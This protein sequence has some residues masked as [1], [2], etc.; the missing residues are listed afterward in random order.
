MN[1]HRT[2]Q[3]NGSW[4]VLCVLLPAWAAWGQTAT[5]PVE[6]APATAPASEPASPTTAPNRDFLDVP[7]DNRVAEALKFSEEEMIVLDDTSNDSTN[8]PSSDPGVPILLQHI[9]KIKRFTK[10]EFAQLEPGIVRLMRKHGREDYHLY[11]IQMDVKVNAISRFTPVKSKYWPQ[12]KPVWKLDCLS[13]NTP[14]GPDKDNPNIASILIAEDMTSLLGTPDKKKTEG[15]VERWDYE[16]NP[17]RMQFAG[18]FYRNY[19]SGTDDPKNH[20]EQRAYPLVIAWQNLRTDTA[21]SSNVSG[22]QLSIAGGAILLVF[23]LWLWLRQMA[24]GRS[25]AEDDRLRQRQADDFVPSQRD[26][27]QMDPELLAAAEAYFKEHAD[28]RPVSHSKP[29]LKTYDAAGEEFIEV[30]PALRAAA[31]QFKKDH[32]GGKRS[33]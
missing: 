16:K 19:F 31:E 21:T 32:P 4:I 15:G 25:H 30:A 13:L 24:K 9:S 11:P 5:S 20:P 14:G 22:W 12:D 27:E 2:T 26:I 7:M 23:G 1:T 8:P 10:E 17:R 29:V 6:S 28:K 33:G 3:R 18:I